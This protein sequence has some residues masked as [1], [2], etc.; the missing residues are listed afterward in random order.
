MSTETAKII[1]DKLYAILVA[2]FVIFSFI[3]VYISMHWGIGLTPD[4]L[5]YIRIADELASGAG[6][7]ASQHY[8]PLY[9]FLLFISSIVFDDTLI[10][11]RWM[12]IFIY[13]A[14]IILTSVILK[15]TSEQGNGWALAGIF[16]LFTAPHLFSVYMMAWSEPLFLMLI[17]AGFYFLALH[18]SS[19]KTLALFYSA[20]FMALAFATR[21]VGIVPVGAA[22]LSLLVF[23]RQG[24]TV[25]LK[26]AALFA[27]LSLF[28]MLLWLLWGQITKEPG[29]PRVFAYHPISIEK[30]QSGYGEMLD[31][32]QLGSPVSWLVLSVFLVSYIFLVRSCRAGKQEPP[33]T[34]E[35]LGKILLLFIPMYLGFLLISISY[36]DA[37]TPLDTR[38]LIPVYFFL[39]IALVSG[40]SSVMSQTKRCKA[41]NI[42]A[43]LVVLLLIFL[44]FMQFQNMVNYFSKNGVG[45]LSRQW[46]QSDT[47]AYLKNNP[48][49]QRLIFTNSPEIIEIHLKKESK[50]LP[51]RES[52][53]S[54]KVN[55]DFTNSL[56]RLQQEFIRNDAVLVY[57][58]T[59][60]YRTYLPSLKELSDSI[61]MDIIYKGRDGIVLQAHK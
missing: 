23:L 48:P 50:F 31:W 11:A 44:Q 46:V 18:L 42:T 17:L 60:S 15:K 6:A 8:P 40:L 53:T 7:S 34:A 61:E 55:K 10:A 58:Y 39:V 38:I 3:L 30:L 22:I 57:F 16:V 29:S 51:Q 5:V 14:T 49:G 41:F 25:R 45:F 27:F 52:A 13:L 33:A 24:W 36:F 47:L 26:S 19:Q 9:S 54:K 37:H 1:S 12:G 2:A 21:Y 28:P 20:L 4:S 59:F 35:S 32:F 56:Q 43:L